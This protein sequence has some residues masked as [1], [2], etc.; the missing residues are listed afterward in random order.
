MVTSKSKPQKSLALLEKH[1]V[2][3]IKLVDKAHGII[4]QNWSMMSSVEKR[5]SPRFRQAATHVIPTLVQ[6]GQRYGV[7]VPNRPVDEMDVTLQRSTTLAPLRDALRFLLQKVE[8]AM[9]QESGSSWKTATTVYT[10]LRR[11]SKD[12]AELAALLAPL[13]PSFRTRQRAKKSEPASGTNATPTTVPGASSG[14]TVT[15]A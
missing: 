8:D 11:W 6:L 14:G 5:R 2:E 4:G 15:H 9:L 12:D 10:T 13:E 7:N 1:V 3:C